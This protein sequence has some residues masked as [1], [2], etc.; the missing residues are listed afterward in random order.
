MKSSK[1]PPLPLYNP[2]PSSPNP[3]LGPLD[4]IRRKIPHINT[5]LRIT[6]ENGNLNR[7]ISP[8]ASQ[9]SPRGRSHGNPVGKPPGHGKTGSIN[10]S[11]NGSMKREALLFRI[12]LSLIV[13][14]ISVTLLLYTWVPGY[15]P[16]SLYSADA[17]SLSSLE[18]QG[19]GP[20]N[21]GSNSKANLGILSSSSSL[22]FSSFQSPAV[23]DALLDL[24]PAQRLSVLECSQLGRSCSVKNLYVLSSALHAY[25]GPE[26]SV[27]ELHDL[28]IYTGYGSGTPVIRIHVVGE[29]GEEPP[30]AIIEDKSVGSKT[31]LIIHLFVHRALPPQRSSLSQ[32]FKMRAFTQPVVLF[33]VLWQNLFRTMYAGVGALNSLM[34]HGLYFPGKHRFIL[35]DPA[36]PANFLGILQTLTP[37]EIKWFEEMDDGL[38]KAVV[39][40]ISRFGA[41]EEILVEDFVD[42]GHYLRQNAFR[43]FSQQVRAH[44]LKIT[45]AEAARVNDWSV[46]PASPAGAGKSKRLPVVTY[47]SR[48][49][50]RTILNEKE[51]LQRLQELPVQVN[52][53]KFEELT[54]EKQIEIA[55]R[56]DIFITLHGAAM[57]Q[58]VFLREGSYVLELF[59]FAFRKVIYQNIAKIAG[60][61]YMSWQNRDMAKTV[62]RWDLVEKR[63]LTTMPKERVVNFPIDWY[64]MDSKNYWRNQ[65]T[66]VNVDEIFSLVKFMVSHA[67]DPEGFR[68]LMNAPWEQ[69]NNQLLE[70]SSACALGL[71]LDRAVVLPKIGYRD[72][73]PVQPETT[74][75]YSYYDDEEDDEDG[76]IPLSFNKDFDKGPTTLLPFS[77]LNYTWNPLEKYFSPRPLLDLPCA[78]ISFENFVSLNAGRSLGKLRYH[79]LGDAT[80]VTQLTEYYGNISHFVFDS[81]EED[82]NAYTHQSL[83]EVRALHSANADRV[84]A[85][86]ALFW[87]FD[88]GI[89]PTYPLD[90]VYNHLDH[91]VYRKIQEALQFNPFLEDLASRSLLKLPKQFVALHLRRG[92]YLAKCDAIQQERPSLFDKCYQTNT[93]V[94][95]FLKTLGAKTAVF[96]ATNPETN[97]ENLR[98]VAG[99]KRKLYFLE[100]I[101]APL[102]EPWAL[103]TLD[104]VER[105]IVEQIICIKAERFVGNL[106]SSFSKTI[107][108]NRTLQGRNETSVF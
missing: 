42:F 61:R 37:F 84:L 107:I 7:G 104:P 16:L 3:G 4:S 82:P 57:A 23:N 69:Y 78:T 99:D 30:Q 77:P 62:L 85:L 55:H 64:N 9:N 8:E 24:P 70:F 27:A 19:K 46:A 22:S 31:P 68:F 49:G 12:F 53:Y 10:G 15:A 52:A 83:D 25:V 51:M 71:I 102:S 105:S 54:L 106:Y 74:S 5:S 81:V 43:Y 44:V 98:K 108:E 90:R 73:I 48:T 63:Q 32:F 6:T 39:L 91:P 100:D 59:P 13:M 76:N 60:L 94:K 34:Q 36:R 87:Y 28:N 29:G 96:I 75:E 21:P 93:Y 11:I 35:V 17:S 14:T 89:K 33:S 97:R 56:T 88:F 38:Y 95:K 2:G 66:V 67:A 80:S 41:V 47:V 40:G 58:T 79:S 20:P 86:G 1:D 18:T 92:D 50:V 26:A 103:S 45:E 65:D 101:L 72:H